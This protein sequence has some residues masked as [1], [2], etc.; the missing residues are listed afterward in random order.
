M[1]LLT[2]YDQ[3]YREEWPYLTGRELQEERHVVVLFPH[4]DDESFVAAGTIAL[5]NQYGI[6]VT[7]I[8][9]TLGE[10]GRRMG[11]PVLANRETLPELRKQELE[12]ACAILGIS[13]LR[14]L[15][16]RDKTLEFEDEEW[17][18]SQIGDLLSEIHPSLVITFYPGHAIHPDHDA[19]AYA[20]VEAVARMPEEIRPTVYCRAISP[21]RFEALGKPDVVIDISTVADKKIAAMK[22]HQSQTKEMM[23]ELEQKIAAEEPEAM[24]WVQREEFWTY[25]F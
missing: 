1:F 10:M 14:L 2:V 9:A 4:P 8:C 16:L 18:I 21:Q 23:K 19:L 3:D 17:L 20:A 25:Q 11:H 13:D 7:Y 22:A 5:L 15:G 12:R 24:R 6:P